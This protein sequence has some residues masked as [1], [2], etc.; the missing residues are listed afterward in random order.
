MFMNYCKKKSLILL[1]KLVLCAAF[2]NGNCEVFIW[3]QAYT[4]QQIAK[5]YNR[6]AETLTSY[7]VRT[8]AFSRLTN[9]RLPSIPTSN[10]SDEVIIRHIRGIVILLT[11]ITRFYDQNSNQAIKKL[12]HSL[13]HAQT[14]KT[15]YLSVHKELEK[16]LERATS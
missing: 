4:T 2:L 14:N 5:Q 9:M 1:L 15:A 3:N 6:A 7:I 8:H 11:H 13:K 16:A 12:L 10:M